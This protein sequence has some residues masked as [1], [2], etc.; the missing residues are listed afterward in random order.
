LILE[1]ARVQRRWEDWLRQPSRELAM[2]A[3][4]GDW[5]SCA[6]AEFAGI[7]RRMD[8]DEFDAVDDFIADNYPP[9]HSLGHAFFDAVKAE[10]YADAEKIRIR[11]FRHAKRM[12][13]SGHVLEG[14][15]QSSP[16][17]RLPEGFP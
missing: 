7:N 14:P 16:W 13:F 9:I 15:S 4:A 2:V 6:L 17:E 5:G 8:L 1:T 10:R 11:I 3:E 12:F